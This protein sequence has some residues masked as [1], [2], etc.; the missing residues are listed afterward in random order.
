MKPTLTE[1]SLDINKNV[2]LAHVKQHLKI[3]SGIIKSLSTTLN[4]KM[5][6][7]YQKNFEKSKAQWNT[8]NYME[9]YIL[10]LNDKYEITT[11]KGDNFL[12]KRAEIIINAYRHRSK[13]KLVNCEA[14][15]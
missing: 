13:Y 4:I 12:N 7:N 9:N 1:T 5:I 2:T 14:I 8:K 15:D 11:Y 3:V 10:C 6:R